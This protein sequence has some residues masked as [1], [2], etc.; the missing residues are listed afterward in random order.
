MYKGSRFALASIKSYLAFKSY[1]ERVVISSHESMARRG[2]PIFE[3]KS[4]ATD[5]MTMGTVPTSI[6][7]HVR[8]QSSPFPRGDATKRY[9]IRDSRYFFGCGHPVSSSASGNRERK[10]YAGWRSS[11][12][13][14]IL[15][16]KIILLLRVAAVAFE[17][18]FL[19]AASKT[20]GTPKL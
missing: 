13:D 11:G 5:F 10:S 6:A 1:S 18:L 4:L 9:D 7:S 14:L 8:W 3:K 20:F 15:N 17:I 2:S 12:F 16:L 19:T